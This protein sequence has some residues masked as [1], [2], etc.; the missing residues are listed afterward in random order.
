MSKICK[1]RT[2]VGEVEGPRKGPVLAPR[3]PLMLLARIRK[4]SKII[5]GTHFESLGS[6][7]TSK[8]PS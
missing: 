1:A 7:V 5:L 4:S 6:H 3:L 8:S 2:K